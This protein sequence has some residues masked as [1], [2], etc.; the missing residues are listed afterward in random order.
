MAKLF[1]YL[2]ELAGFAATGLAGIHGTGAKEQK[3]IST[4]P[5]MVKELSQHSA[6]DELVRGTASIRRRRVHVKIDH[7]ITPSRPRI[8]GRGSWVVGSWVGDRT[9]ERKGSGISTRAHSRCPS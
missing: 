4:L 1:L 8:V 9:T 7:S 5:D 3:E 6:L 2:S